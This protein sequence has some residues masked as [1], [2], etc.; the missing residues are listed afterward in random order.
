MFKLGITG[1]IASGKST[2]V[3]WLKQQHIP[4]IDADMVAREVVEPNT[5]GLQAI[6][7]HFGDTVL[8]TDGTLHRETLGQIVF[9]NDNERLKLNE[10]LTGYIRARIME[11]TCQYEQN[12]EALVMYDIPLMIE[13]S[14]HT[15]MDALWV[16]YVTK[17]TQINRLMHRNNYSRE[18]ALARIHSQIS[19]DEKRAY[20]T[21]VIDNNGTEQELYNQLQSAYTG[22]K[23]NL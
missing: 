8:H 10:I 15:M 11:L 13:G 12:G 16:I 7:K 14:W 19:L 6:V 17:D 2:A 5:P 21:V 22:L 9:H 18:D 4:C 20:A 23:V 3:A 1:G